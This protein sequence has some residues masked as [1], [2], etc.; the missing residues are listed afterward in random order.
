MQNLN[1]A[2]LGTDI[3]EVERIRKIY[4]RFG[5]KFLKRVYTPLEQEYCLNFHQ[6]AERLAGRFAAKEAV[7]K[8]IGRGFQDK[9]SFQD[10]EI[11]NDSF[12]KPHVNLSVRLEKELGNFNL[13]VS[14]SHCKE[15]A[16][17]TAIFLS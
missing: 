7:A 2:S 10:I 3:I 1:N 11:L 17:A 5:S 12:G 6:P 13:L 9:I 8:A 16:T 15:Y 4:V 14:L